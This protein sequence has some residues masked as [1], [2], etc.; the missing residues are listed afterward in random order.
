MLNN[1]QQRI[2]EWEDKINNPELTNELI[3]GHYIGELDMIKWTLDEVLI[4]VQDR[5]LQLR[6][7]SDDDMA[8]FG[9]NELKEIEQSILKIRKIEE[10]IKV[11]EG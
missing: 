1:I 5:M 2:K 9:L 4:D 8:M 3:R 11:Q 6:Q 10:Q 7:Y